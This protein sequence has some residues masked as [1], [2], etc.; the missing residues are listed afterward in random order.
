[1]ILNYLAVDPGDVHQGVA[2]FELDCAF[3]EGT[4]TGNWS[5]IRHWTRDLNRR[6]LFKLVED[7]SIDALVIEAFRLYPELAREQGYSE[8][9]TSQ[10]IGVLR[11]IADG[12]E[13]PYTI[14]G[15][16]TKKQ[17]RRIGE[18]QG[19]PGKIRMLGTGRNRYRGW[20]FDGP[21]QHERDAT[22][23]GVW[24]GFN[25]NDSPVKGLHNKGE[26]RLVLPGEV[27]RA[28]R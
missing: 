20:D 22:A 10:T 18:R 17:A 11:Y 5:M 26:C 14:Q 3:D 12:R 28:S 25:H 1:M 9:L 19:F 15:G 2:Y 4:Q 27:A 21:S 16:S 13:I 23:H 8:F 7:G 6:S 24:W